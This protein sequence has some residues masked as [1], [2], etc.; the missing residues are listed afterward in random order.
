M[1]VV[2]P[3]LSDSVET[4]QPIES[5]ATRRES[6]HNAAT[7]LHWHRAQAHPLDPRPGR[8]TLMSNAAAPGSGKDQL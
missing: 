7:T 5:R 8:P 4:G 2:P 6:T 1:T 3:V